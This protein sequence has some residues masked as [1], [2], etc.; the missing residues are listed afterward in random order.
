MS[1]PETTFDL[2]FL[3]IKMK[4]MSGLDLATHIRKTDK[5]M[6]IVFVTNHKQYSLR[7]Y[8]V[9]ALHYLIKPPPNTVLIPLLDKANTIWRSKKSEVLMVPNGEGRTKL[10]LDEIFFVS[11]FSHIAKIQTF[12]KEYEIRKTAEELATLLPDYFIRCHRSYIVNLFKVDCVYK[13]SLLLSNGDSL[14]ISRNKSRETYE[15]FIKLHTVR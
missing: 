12:S 1:W 7:G 4:N 5:H 9:D 11:M 2:A 15:A 10:M 6:M 8:D 13:E 14:P 3:D